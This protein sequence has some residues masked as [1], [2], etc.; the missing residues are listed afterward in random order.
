MTTVRRDIE[1]STASQDVWAALVDFGNVHRRVAA[2][3]VR[4]CQ[5]DGDDRIVT[6]ANGVIARERLVGVDTQ[7]RRLAYT[8][9][10][11]PLGS[12]HHQASVEVIESPA[13]GDSCRLVWIT[14]ILPNE[15]AERVAEMMDAG[16]A[17]MMHCLSTPQPADDERAMQA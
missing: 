12:T 8:V 15:L 13:G 16:A 9:V 7:A 14:D 2:D 1:I 11:G 4:E 17:A 6:F 10:D 3:F 5:S